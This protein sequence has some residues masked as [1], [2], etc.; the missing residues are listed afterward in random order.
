ME[1]MKRRYAFTIRVATKDSVCTYTISAASQAE[2][3]AAG[4]KIA[5]IQGVIAV[6]VKPVL[7]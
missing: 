7:H 1:A 2:A 4:I 5:R 3:D 6:S